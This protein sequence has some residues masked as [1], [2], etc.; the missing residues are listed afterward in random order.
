MIIRRVIAAA[1]TLAL[2]STG[3]IVL[4]VAG[5]PPASAAP[6]PIKVG[7]VCSCTGAA[8]AA[9]VL[10]TDGYLAWAKATNAKGGIAGH[11]IDVIDVNDQSTPGTSITLAHQLVSD[12]VVAV[13]VSSLVQQ[14]I[15]P[16]FA[17][18]GIPVVGEAY[19]VA[20]LPQNTDV[21]GTTDTIAPASLSATEDVDL[22]KAAHVK[23]MA[24]L[25]ETTAAS[26]GLT[27]AEL[28]AAAA[29]AGIKVVYSV[30]TSLTQTNYEA[31]CIA[32]QQAGATGLIDGA[33]APLNVENVATSCSLE[34][35]KPVYFVSAQ[36]WNGI[37]APLA[38][39][40][41]MS[42][43]TAPPFDTAIPA[44]RL[45]R[46]TVSKYFPGALQNSNLDPEVQIST[47]EG[48][49]LLHDALV[50]AHLTSSEKVTSKLIVKGLYALKG[51]SLGGLA[52]PI[53]YEHGT[54][55]VL[56]CWFESAQ[57]NGKVSILNGG[58]GVCA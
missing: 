18:A 13:M 26:T 41:Y 37:S 55:H 43:A 33:G 19:G 30:A 29:K 58:K 39:D 22:A 34:N 50:A 10:V 45:W 38:K 25:Y 40:S 12:G 44:I 6:A 31:E 27:T 4:S 57:V 8:G 53:T 42:S 5:A 2:A 20:G 17:S 28:T 14:A 3:L 49:L 48:G 16:V 24:Y 11:Q 47:Y 46:D 21:F 9:F 35:Y 51:D 36:N 7:V 52:P 23:K 1:L 56:D 54:T 32:A 15:L